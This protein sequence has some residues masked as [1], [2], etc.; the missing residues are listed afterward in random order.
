MS[1]Y[2]D[3]ILVHRW[4]HGE[5]FDV[6]IMWIDPMNVV[7]GVYEMHVVDNWVVSFHKPSFKKPMRP[8][9]WILKMLY[10][11]KGDEMVIGETSFLVIP[12]AFH[13][14]KE[15]SLEKA[16][17][18]N[19]GPPGGIY[20]NDYLIEFDREGKNT[21]R[22]VT[23]ATVNA[24]KV[25]EELHKWIDDVVGKF[26]TVEG[27]C[28]VEGESPKCAKLT[29]CKD[30]EWSSRSPD[31]KSEIGKVQPNGRLR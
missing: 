22:L 7:S 6:K 8:G 14:G 23:E 16:I 1:P 3:P 15:I 31:P 5:D 21:E 28:V 9:R 12:L 26:W 11:H 2:D 27:S 13:E 17:E 10:S 30:V 20:N 29:S 18:I 19:H 4:V 25:G 24:R